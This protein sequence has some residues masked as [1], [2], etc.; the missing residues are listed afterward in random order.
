[1]ADFEEGFRVSKNFKK[2]EVIFEYALCMPCLNGMMDEASDESKQRLE[3]FHEEHARDVSGFS[4][5]ALCEKTLESSREKEYSLVGVCH[6][7]KMYDSALICGDCL[8]RLAEI[9]SEETRRGWDRFKEE[10]FPGVPGDLEPMPA[11]PAPALT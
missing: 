5:C 8:D 4:E 3:E 7:E 2:E 6:G 9:T 1:L 10:N 11:R